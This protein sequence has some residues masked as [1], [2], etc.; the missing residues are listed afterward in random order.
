MTWSL[1]PKNFLEIWLERD[2][3]ALKGLKSD[4]RVRVFGWV[5][6]CWTWWWEFRR[7]GDIY[8]IK[9]T[10]NAQEKAV[11]WL[12]GWGVKR[13]KTQKLTLFYHSSGKMVKTHNLPTVQSVMPCLAVPMDLGIRSRHGTTHLTPLVEI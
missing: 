3:D 9:M 6:S 4:E 2:L 1:V 5:L 12:F 8:N 10:S 7:G 11:L 13:I